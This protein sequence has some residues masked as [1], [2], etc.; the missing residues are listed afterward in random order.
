MRIIARRTLR[1]FVA[2]RARHKDH[3]A[4]KAALAA[5]FSEVRR[6]RW[7][8]AADVRRLYAT[9]S[10]VTAERIVFNIRGNAYRLVVSVDFEKSIVR[11]KWWLGTHRE[12]DRIDV[13]KVQH[14]K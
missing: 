12:Y 9:A 14:E 2:S 5:W 7:R 10:I 3:A 13:T 4:L 6:A 11:I 1:E 8:N